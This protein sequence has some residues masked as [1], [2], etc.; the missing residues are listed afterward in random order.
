M[1]DLTGWPNACPLGHPK[2]PR[3][4]LAFTEIPSP[5]QV[6]T[7]SQVW[8]RPGKGLGIWRKLA[9]FLKGTYKGGKHQDK[10]LELILCKSQ[11]S[12]WL[13]TQVLLVLN[14]LNWLISRDIGT[15]LQLTALW[16]HQDMII[17][18]NMIKIE[19]MWLFKYICIVPIIQILTNL[20]HTCVCYLESDVVS[21]WWF[22]RL[23][24]SWF[25]TTVL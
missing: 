8:I 4:E 11:H 16:P 10:S 22:A 3:A 7:M 18:W 15:H 5:T 19:K 6:Q 21:V 12:I 24:E 17:A 9:K 14:L 2:K 20:D 13:N 23:G 1:V 25:I